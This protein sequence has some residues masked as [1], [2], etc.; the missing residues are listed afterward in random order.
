MIASGPGGAT[1]SVWPSGSACAARSAPMLPPAPV[2]C[3][4]MIG[5]PH[6]ACSL[7][8]TMRASTS[9]MPPAGN[10]TM[11]LTGLLGNAPCALDGQRQRREQSGGGQ[12][13]HETHCCSSRCDFQG[14]PRHCPALKAVEPLRVV[15]HDPLGEIGGRQ[16]GEEIVHQRF[17]G[18]RAI[19]RFERRALLL[20]MRRRMRPVAAPDAAVRRG[21][22]ER[23]KPFAGRAWCSAARGRD[24]RAP[25]ASSRHAADATRSSRRR[26]SALSGRASP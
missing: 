22:D 10:G 14:A 24:D 12:T 23:R 6:L 25:T 13:K 2:F 3:S 4:M 1:S 8:A 19:R 26:P 21:G 11:N 16:R 20:L 5:W 9:L 18:Q 7:S 15:A 17:V